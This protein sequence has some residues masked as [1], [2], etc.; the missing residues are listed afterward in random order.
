M[1]AVDI[2]KI[3]MPKLVFSYKKKNKRKEKAL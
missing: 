1:N 2:G 3:N